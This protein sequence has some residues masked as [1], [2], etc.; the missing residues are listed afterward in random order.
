MVDMVKDIVNAGAQLSVSGACIPAL[1]EDLTPWTASYTYQPDH[2]DLDE[3][4]RVTFPGP[5]TF[6]EH[7]VNKMPK[8]DL[9]EFIKCQAEQCLSQV[10]EPEEMEDY[11]LWKIMDLF[12]RQN[13]GSVIVQYVWCLTL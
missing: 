10:K 4:D 12:C 5:R 9:L 11:F 7:S 6:I 2:D 3:L 13:G 1:T 8:E